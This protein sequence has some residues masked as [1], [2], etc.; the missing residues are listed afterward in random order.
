[1]RQPAFPASVSDDKLNIFNKLP[2]PSNDRA[3]DVLTDEQSQRDQK[4][5][6]S[7]FE[8]LANQQSATS[9]LSKQKYKQNVIKQSASEEVSL[10]NLTSTTPQSTKIS[11]SGSNPSLSSSAATTEKPSNTITDVAELNASEKRKIFEQFSSAN[12]NKQPPK[13]MLKTEYNSTQRKSKD[14]T[15]STSPTNVSPVDKIHQESGFSTVEHATKFSTIDREPEKINEVDAGPRKVSDTNK[16]AASLQNLIDELEEMTRDVEDTPPTVPNS[17]N[18]NINESPATFEILQMLE[19]S[20]ENVVDNSDHDIGGQAMTDKSQPPPIPPLANKPARG[21]TLRWVKG[22]NYPLDSLHPKFRELL[23]EKARV[24]QRWF[25]TIQSGKLQ[26]RK[27][28]KSVELVDQTRWNSVAC[29]SDSR[30]ERWNLPDSDFMDE[31]VDSGIDTVA[32]RRLAIALRTREE[33]LREAK[34]MQNADS[35]IDL[36]LP[37]TPIEEIISH[38]PDMLSS[39]STPEIPVISNEDSSNHND[40]DTGKIEFGAGKEVTTVERNIEKKSPISS[41]TPGLKTKTKT[42]INKTQPTNLKKKKPSSKTSDNK[43]TT[44]E[45]GKNLPECP[46]PH[47][48]S[49]NFLYTLTETSSSPIP[50]PEPI[51][52]PTD[53]LSDL[54]QPSHPELDISD[55][56]ND[57]FEDTAYPLIEEQPHRTESPTQTQHNPSPPP[58]PDNETKPLQPAQPTNEETKTEQEQQE[59]SGSCM[60]LSNGIGEQGMSWKADETSRRVDRILDFLKNV[61]DDDAKSSVSGGV[62]VSIGSESIKSFSNSPDTTVFDGVKAKI[63]GQQLEIEE[64]SRII[65]LLKEELKKARDFNNEQGLQYKKDLKSKLTIQR[66]E[67]ETILKR[68][69]SFIDKVL[70]EKEELTT[71]CENL[72][73]EVKTLEKQYKDKF[74]NVEEKHARDI[75]QQREMWQAA[76]KLKRD[77]WIQEKTKAIK[78]QT[79]KGLEPEIQRMI[80]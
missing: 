22:V 53:M 78:E 52:E 32:M 60:N 24:I 46:K 80:A 7:Y 17:I 45:N 49:T 63:M 43:N 66:K 31:K 19:N 20:A 35:A 67:Y 14:S 75:K 79:V 56:L 72:T 27:P 59:Q 57:P 16:L 38:E 74:S 47:T 77:K 3:P 9:S 44:T 50:P 2:P 48:K 12:A 23:H 1:M 29:S 58:E 61:E 55:Y 70:A 40:E 76:E 36:L 25:R 65:S 10:S 69:L 21:E 18:Q 6:R 41:P 8:D 51:P 62:K 11:I 30:R 68:H 5:K 26:N 64:K 73:E 34:F 42:G 28:L 13:P 15:S 4:S 54:P 33:L 37:T 71:K 39:H